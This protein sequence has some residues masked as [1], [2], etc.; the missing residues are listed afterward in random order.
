MAK[1]TIKCDAKK[2]FFTPCYASDGLSALDKQTGKCLGCGK[3]A[4]EIET[5]VQEKVVE[6]V[7]E[8][9]ALTPDQEKEVKRIHRYNYRFSQA[10][11][12][13]MLPGVIEG[14]KGWDTDLPIVLREKLTEKFNKLLEGKNVEQDSVDLANYCMMIWR[15]TQK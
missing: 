14:K 11:E 9:T 8:K 13:A 7:I 12:E 6:K 1:K 2:D 5:P 3:T 15:K 4:K 10:M